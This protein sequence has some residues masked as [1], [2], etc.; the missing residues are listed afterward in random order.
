MRT[1]L[2]TT[3]A[4]DFPRRG[5]PS[6]PPAGLLRRRDAG[7]RPRAPPHNGRHFGSMC[8]TTT[9]TPTELVAPSAVVYG[10]AVRKSTT[11]NARHT[12]R[13]RSFRKEARPGAYTVVVFLN[14]PH[15]PQN[16]TWP[17]PPAHP[18][19]VVV[20]VTVVLAS[21]TGLWMVAS[22]V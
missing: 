15:S 21:R 19:V 16:V 11:T 9:R 7:P 17:R 2:A 5:G 18:T 3:R 20:F 1:V 14:T 6:T 10:K 8:P 12:P 22:S 13:S 4:R